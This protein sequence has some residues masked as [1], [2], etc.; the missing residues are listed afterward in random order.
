MKTLIVKSGEFCRFLVTHHPEYRTA[1]LAEQMPPGVECVML[2]VTRVKSKDIKA[3]FPQLAVDA[4]WYRLTP[5][6]EQYLA[7]V[8]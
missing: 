3:R 2:G 5:E 1:K 7:S 8:C 6:L 4:V